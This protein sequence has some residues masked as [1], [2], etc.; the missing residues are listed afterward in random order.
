MAPQAWADPRSPPAPMSVEELE[1]ELGMDLAALDAAAAHTHTGV[2]R[3]SDL[4]FDSPDSASLLHEYVKEG[5][6]VGEEQGMDLDAALALFFPD[7]ALDGATAHNH[8]GV[9]RCSD[10]LF[11][12]CIPTTLVIHEYVAAWVEESEEEWE[13]EMGRRE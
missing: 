8:T 13:E 3:C 6:R 9:D 4:L 5:R 11:E 12:Y 2:D 7:S 10:L 1:E